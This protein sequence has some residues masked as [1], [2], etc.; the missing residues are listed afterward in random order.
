MLRA[1]P[2]TPEFWHIPDL[3]QGV[4]VG[5]NEKVGYKR[6]NSGAGKAVPQPRLDEFQNFIGYS[7]YFH[8]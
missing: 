4:R 1:W 7:S 5:K 3:C 6:E 8:I 2:S